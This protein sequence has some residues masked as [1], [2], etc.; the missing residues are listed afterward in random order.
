M[1]AIQQTLK[2]RGY[3]LPAEWAPQRAVL[4]TWP[5][6]VLTWPHQLDKVREAYIK[7]IREISDSQDVWL[8][9]DNITMELEVTRRLRLGCVATERVKF[10]HIPAYDS[11]IRDYGPITLAHQKLPP[12]M[13]DW[14]FNGWGGKYDDGYASD[15][16]LP[17][18]LSSM[19][20]LERTEIPMI[21]EGGSID[22]NG[23]GTVITT[24]D[25]LLNSNR[26]ETFSKDFIENQLKQNLGVNHVIWLAGEIKGDDTDGHI[27]DSVRFVD[28]TT[29]CC[30]LESNPDDINFEPTQRLYDSLKSQ[31]LESGLPLR[32]VSLPMPKPVYYDDIRLPASYANF[33]ITNHKVLVPIYHCPQD[34]V[35]LDVL[36]SCFPTR[37]VV[38]IDCRDVVYGLG[39]IHCLSMQIPA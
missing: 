27:D 13:T 22:V 24:V 36:Q 4:L 2:D 14:I 17:A 18:K 34:N 7:I 20:N 29:V 6:N 1:S 9:V 26:N 31:R 35:A 37:K 19:V 25:C 5:R 30:I 23:Q 15:S 28:E 38:G 8:V 10:L 33:L 12:M 39:A 32:V 3:Y 11:W 21:L 16:V